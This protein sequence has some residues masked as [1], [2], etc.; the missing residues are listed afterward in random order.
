MIEND[1]R[2]V[3][4]RLDSI[5]TSQS[6]TNAQNEEIIGLLNKINEKITPKQEMNVAPKQ[7]ENEKQ[8]L[9]K[10]AQSSKKEHVW[11]GPIDEFNKSKTIVRIICIC[12]IVV[13]IISTI[14]T[15]LAIRFYTTFTLF[16]NIWLIFICIIFAYSIYAKKRMIDVD[17]KDHSCYAFIQD[18]DGTWRDTNKEKKR[19]KVFRIISYISVVGNIIVVWVYTRGIIAILATIFELAFAGLSVGLYFA[20][21]NLFCMYGNFI[22]YTGKIGNMAQEITLLFDVFGNK[23]ATIEEVPE[24]MKKML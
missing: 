5:E 6:L 24:N 23:T 13:A 9:Q 19:F 2:S 15:S 10:F 17:L 1:E 21:V 22:L 12:L 7:Q 14:L 4:E 3:N 11:F 18:E 8:L 20:Y 16:E